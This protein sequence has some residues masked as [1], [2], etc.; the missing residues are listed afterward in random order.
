MCRN[1]IPG[2]GIKKEAWIEVAE[3]NHVTHVGLKP[4]MVKDVI[5]KQSNAM[6]QIM[7]GEKVELKLQELGWRKEAEFCSVIRNWYQAEDKPELDVLQRHKARMGPF[8][9][10][11]SPSNGPGT[12]KYRP[13]DS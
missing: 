1:G 13:A 5:D 4:A 3:S 12:S 9:A 6:A 2:L 11:R 8:A 10:E 7:F